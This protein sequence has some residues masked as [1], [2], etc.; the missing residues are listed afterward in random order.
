MG[1]DRPNHQIDPRLNG[2]WNLSTKSTRLH[3]FGPLSDRILTSVFDRVLIRMPKLIA[4]GV[5]S[6]RGIDRRKWVFLSLANSQDIVAVL[7]A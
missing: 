1:F 6:F 2:I 4:I 5:I 3:K 7:L